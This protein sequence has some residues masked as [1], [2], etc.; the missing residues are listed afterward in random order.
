MEIKGQIH[1]YTTDGNQHSSIKSDLHQSTKQLVFLIATNPAVE[2]GLFQGPS[3]LLPPW[4]MLQL[5]VLWRGADWAS[6]AVHFAVQSGR[7]CSCDHKKRPQS[8][9]LRITALAESQS[10]SAPAQ[11]MLAGFAAP[12]SRGL[13]ELHNARLC[14]V[15]HYSE[16]LNNSVCR[17]NGICHWNTFHMEAGSLQGCQH[18]SPAAEPVLGAAAFLQHNNPGVGGLGWQGV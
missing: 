15:I 12:G 2:K 17:N 7:C 13:R 14:S 6:A 3:P 18:S 8:Q 4:E 5:H 16:L 10:C 1:R 11:G 9:F